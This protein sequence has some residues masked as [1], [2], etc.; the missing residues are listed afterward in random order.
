MAKVY[1]G[2][3]PFS[4]SPIDQ[5][6]LENQQRAQ[7]MQE[8]EAQQQQQQSGGILPGL[9]ATGAAVYGGSELLGGGASA[10]P[11]SSL[12]SSE[13]A[14]AA[15]NAPALA[16]TGAAPSGW[17]LGGIGTAGNYIAPAAGA[18]GALDV[19][20]NKKHGAGG[21]L[22]GAASGAALGSYFGPYGALAGGLLGG[23]IGYFGNFGDKNEFQG[24]YKR[25]QALRDKGI[26]WN[27]NTEKPK[28]GRSLDELLGIEQAKIN[29]GQYGNT[30]FAKSRKE[31]DLKGKDIWGYSAFGEKFGNDWF[32]KFSEAQREK[33]AQDAID[34]GAV[35]EAKGQIDVDWSK[36]PSLDELTKAPT[37]TRSPGFDKNGKRINYGGGRVK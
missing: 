7:A 17:A 36:L 34:K 19:L 12:V 22:E 26:N 21:A 10:L 4:M 25:A 32:G 16:A 6:I 29:A 20:A 33:I 30:T 13:A 14:N 35:K 8:A 28:K 2:T 24:E 27:L 3:P 15:W 31:S 5:L 1:L 37:P 23:G 9:A 18:I 11:A